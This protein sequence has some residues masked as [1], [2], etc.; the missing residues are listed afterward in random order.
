MIRLLVGVVIAAFAPLVATAA[1]RIYSPQVKTLQAVVNQDWLSPPVMTLGSD[2]VLNIG[3]DELSHTYHRYIYKIEHCEAD[4][5]TSTGL[6]ESDYLAGFNGNPIEDYQNSLNTIVLYTHYNLQIPNDKC[7]LKMSGN[8][9]LTIYDE[10]NDNERVAEV[11][12]MVTEQTMNVGLMATTNTDIDVNRSHQQV[13]VSVDYGNLSVTNLNEQVCLVVTQNG[14]DDNAKRN[15]R[16]N[17]I[18]TRG[19]RWEHNR[20]LIFTAGNEYHKYELLDVSHPTMGIDRI[21]WNGHN[22]DTYLFPDEPRR[23]YLT[24]E[25]A[26]GYFFIR[27]TDNS[28]IDYTCEYTYVH[29]KLK[30][31]EQYDGTVSVDGHWATDYDRSAYAMEYDE[32]DGSYNAII[33]QK[34]GYYSYQY[35]LNGDIS[36]TEDSFFQ[37]E[38]RYQA[39]VY[40]R[41]TDG[42][43]WR[44][45]GYRQLIFK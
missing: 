6:F 34:Q 17:F 42:R 32:G 4:W 9:R 15:P 25:D 44:L 16:P 38:N 33:L 30:T 23:N 18:N 29:Y 43:T 45:V 19:L 41:K 28:E 37:T 13:S 27:N 10:D 8:Y 3:F 12:F 21:S 22:Y 36:P 5:S 1:N 11:E 31:G 20:D 7:Q 35:L 40:Y 2:D 26:N 24:D 39:Y 14:R